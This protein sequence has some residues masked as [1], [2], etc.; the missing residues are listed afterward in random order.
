MA[1]AFVLLRRIA[2]YTLLLIPVIIADA[3]SFKLYVAE[4]NNASVTSVQLVDS[5][6]G[7][8][9][10]PVFH[11]ETPVIYY[12]KGNDIIGF[13]LSTGERAV[14]FTSNA[15][16]VGLR[17]MSDG[18]SLTFMDQLPSDNL[19]RITVEGGPDPSIKLQSPVENYLW[20][21]DNNLLAVAPGNPNAL[22]LMTVR[23]QRQIS[24]GR[25]V[26]RTLTRDRKSGSFAFVH[27]L[28]VDSWSIKVI[29]QDGSVS[30]VA[31]TLP[32][33]DIFSFTAAG[34][35]IA[36]YEGQ[37]HRYEAKS[38]RWIACEGDFTGDMT[39]LHTSASD[40]KLAFWVK[41]STK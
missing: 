19:R 12:A 18:K 6:N 35:P 28:A 20:M 2:A 10:G 37:L 13:D 25:H 3:Q 33:A 4:M 7:S 27:K 24:V 38:G 16:V 22:N 31:E 5:A 17:L 8:V 39:A 9:A 34:I 32:E 26:G 36:W 21:D 15:R 14:V 40:S 30:I 29:A 41:Q 1:L 23:P 11:E